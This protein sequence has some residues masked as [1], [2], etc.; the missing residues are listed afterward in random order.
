MTCSLMLDRMLEADLD[1]LRGWGESVVATHV[2][3]CTRCRDVANQLVR[4]TGGLSQ[5]IRALP[6]A[7]PARRRSVALPAR[8]AAMAGLAAAVVLIVVRN[9]GRPTGSHTATSA[10][11]MQPVT[12]SPPVAPSVIVAGVAPRAQTRRAST[13][14]ARVVLPTGRAIQPSAVTVEPTAQRAVA[15]LPVRIAPAPQQPL[16]NTVTVE[17]PAGKRANIIRT[18]R[19]GLTVVWLYD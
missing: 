13:R 19:P 18:D 14:V 1:E 16:G 12:V 17:P 8:A 4:D 15:V 6:E 3:G 10:V 11:V 9:T 7:T 2:R 5:S